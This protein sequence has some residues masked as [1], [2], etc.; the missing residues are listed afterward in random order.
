MYDYEE[1]KKGS[2]GLKII[3]LKQTPTSTMLNE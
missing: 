2:N 3:H 1:Q